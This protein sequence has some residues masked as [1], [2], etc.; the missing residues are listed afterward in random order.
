MREDN[1]T[2]NKKAMIAYPL[3]DSL[4]LNITN[5]CTNACVFCIRQTE[6]GV[7]YDLW[8]D[9]EPNVEDLINAIGDPSGYRE[10]VFCGYGEPLLRPD[11]VVGVS[12]WLKENQVR[13]IRLN[14]NGLA[15]LF[16]DDDI[17]PELT[18][19]IDV[20]SISLNAHDGDSYLKLTKSKYGIGSFEALLDF[21]KR[22]MKH[23]PEVILSVVNYP[24]VNIKAAEKLALQI[25]TEFRVRDFQS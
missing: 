13:K 24:G 7:G 3:H 4:Y 1:K 23:F 17:L 5:R 16:L 6:N 15:D 10:V 19:L 9:T 14:T 12:K 25:G 8:L 22:S 11:V 2:K 21:A 20:I 18:G